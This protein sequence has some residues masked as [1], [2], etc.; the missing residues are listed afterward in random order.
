MISRA[1][2]VFLII[3]TITCKLTHIE[4]FYRTK[5]LES[6]ISTHEKADN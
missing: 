1:L 5:S 4:A 3:Y 6:N 2:I